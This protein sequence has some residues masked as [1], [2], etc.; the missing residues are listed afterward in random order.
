MSDFDE[1]D[2]VR[3]K[4][5]K[6]QPIPLLF[7]ESEAAEEIAKKLIAKHHTHLGSARFR[8]I[9]R[10]KATKRSGVP[11]PGNVYKMSNKFEYLVGQDF[12][13]E[14]AL[15]VW[16]NYSP[17]QR[18][19]LIDHLLTRCV[20]EENEENGE[21]KWSVRSPEIQEFAEVAERNGQWNEGLVEMHRCL[22]SSNE[23]G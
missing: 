12:V 14:V 6:T 10:N 21:M 17:Q 11:V 3:D 16:N 4:R 23:H 8:Y 7:G 20:G 18:I 2:A 1:N 19:A 13:I 9:C 15:D 5:K 22:M